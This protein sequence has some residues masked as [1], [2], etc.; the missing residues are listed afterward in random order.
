MYKLKT[1]T[2]ISFYVQYP[3]G[4]VIALQCE[5]EFQESSPGNPGRSEYMALL[6]DTYRSN[7]I[8]KIPL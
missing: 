1:Y 5:N 7:G 3:D 2:N 4:P 8:T 6:E